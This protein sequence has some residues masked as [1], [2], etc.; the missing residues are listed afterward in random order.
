MLALDA[1]ILV[2]AVL[3][4]RARGILE[5][6][7]G[8]V[9]FLVADVAVEEARLHLPG[10]LARRGL[11]PQ[12]ALSVL[13]ALVEKLEV[14]EVEAYGAW[15]E[16]A[17]QR[18]KNRDLD[19]WPVLAVALTFGCGIWTEDADFFGTG[20]PTWTTDRVEILLRSLVAGEAAESRDQ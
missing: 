5:A 7:T 2:R 12:L 17:K 20:V 3:G 8:V 11:D 10:V 6:Y 16:G 15:E 18:L 14:I 1:N 9:Q 13:E 4:K 19:D